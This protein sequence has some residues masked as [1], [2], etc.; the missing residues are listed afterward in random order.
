[1]DTSGK[2]S[3]VIE[4]AKHI[5]MSTLH[6]HSEQLKWD[7]NLELGYN[8]YYTLEKDTSHIYVK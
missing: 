6:I 5:H 4:V 7:S 1:M 3:D 8:I 2:L